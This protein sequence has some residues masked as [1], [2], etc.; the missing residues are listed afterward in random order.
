MTDEKP[1]RPITSCAVSQARV[2]LIL[3]LD[4]C[5]CKPCRGCRTHQICAFPITGA[6]TLVDH[7]KDVGATDLLIPEAGEVLTADFELP[8][9]ELARLVAELLRPEAAEALLKVGAKA[10]NKARQWTEP[11]LGEVMTDILEGVV[12]GSQAC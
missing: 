10:A 2:N 9:A 1:C 6:P 7:N 11:A 4:S 5:N 8:R 12:A 3:I